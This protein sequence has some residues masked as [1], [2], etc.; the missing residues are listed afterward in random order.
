MQATINEL[1]NNEDAER[2][3]IG[4]TLLNQHIPHGARALATTD[5][6]SQTFREA[7]SACLEL[8]ADALPVEPLSVHAI[9]KRNR[10]NVADSFPVSALLATTSGM[11][12][13]NEKPFVSQIRNASTRRFLIRRLNESVKSLS[14]GEKGAIQNLKRELND[15]EHAEEL[16]GNFVSL[17]TIIE[18]D[19]LPGL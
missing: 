7:W 4:L 14:I 8:D 2:N 19:V 18:R 1:P 16:K 3:L 10:P 6:Y 13:V 5:F 9:M 11:A 15:L 17:A 12:N